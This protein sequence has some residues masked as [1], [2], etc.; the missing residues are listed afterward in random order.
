MHL[1]R[2]CF[3]LASYL[4]VAAASAGTLENEFGPG[5]IGFETDENGSAQKSFERH[6]QTRAIGQSIDYSI[7]LDEYSEQYSNT[8]GSDV[9]GFDFD[10]WSENNGDKEDDRNSGGSYRGTAGTP[11]DPLP[12]KDPQDVLLGLRI[13]PPTSN[14]EEIVE[15][16]RTYGPQ[17]IQAGGFKIVVGPEMEIYD[18]GGPVPGDGDEITETERDPDASVPEVDFDDVVNSV[19]QTVGAVVDVIRTTGVGERFIDKVNAVVT[20]MAQATHTAVSNAVED[21][22]ESH[23]GKAF[24]S[25]INEMGQ[26]AG[27][28]HLTGQIPEQIAERQFLGELTIT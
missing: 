27:N 26:P 3:L 24:M 18:V 7:S 8:H 1:F 22:K 15:D 2:F 13:A 17:Y 28:A 20:P 4:I 21:W 19:K 12:H 9:G 16:E 6:Q 10:S 14:G 25:G 5:S 11:E 23:T